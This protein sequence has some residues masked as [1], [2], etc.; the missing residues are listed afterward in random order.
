MV[1]PHPDGPSIGCVL[2]S[3][4]RHP[5]RYF[6]RWNWKSAVL[7]SLVRSGGMTPAMFLICAAA[8]SLEA[9]PRGKQLI[10]HRGA[11]GYAPE[12][13]GAAYLL[14]IQQGADFVEQDL[15]LTKDGELVCLHD[16]AV[17]RRADA[18]CARTRASV[19]PPRVPDGAG[20]CGTVAQPG[21]AEGRGGLRQRH[22]AGQT[23]PRSA[24]RGRQMGARCRPDRDALYVS[25]GDNRPIRKC[26]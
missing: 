1:D 13:T 23:N 19:D 18:A 16:P 10:A 14:A 5:V 25:R 6:R 15:V 11:S 2:R 12:H 21:A 26:P 22:R 3:L 4:C 9:A 24:A 8:L 17:V 7:S 20:H